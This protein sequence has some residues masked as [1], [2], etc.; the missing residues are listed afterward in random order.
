MYTKKYNSV[1]RQACNIFSYKN[2]ETV[3]HIKTAKGLNQAFA[4]CEVTC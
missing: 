2:A 4:L 1:M 3:K